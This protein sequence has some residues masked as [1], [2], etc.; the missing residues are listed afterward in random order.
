MP[1]VLRL[2]R[3]HLSHKCNF[4][5]AYWP[6]WKNNVKSKITFELNFSPAFQTNIFKLIISIPYVVTLWVINIPQET[7]MV[8]RRETYSGEYYFNTVSAVA[9]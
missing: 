2:C 9:L 3:L 8:A 7:W 5:I 6:V 4:I 1:D